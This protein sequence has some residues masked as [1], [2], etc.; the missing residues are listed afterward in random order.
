MAESIGGTYRR[1][2]IHIWMGDHGHPETMSVRDAG[3]RGWAL[4]AA[5]TIAALALL[6]GAW[7]GLFFQ[8]PWNLLFAGLALG[9]PILTLFTVWYLYEVTWSR[10]LRKRQAQE[11]REIA[12]MGTAE[13]LLRLTDYADQLL[14]RLT[15]YTG[16]FFFLALLA[17]FVVPVAFNFVLLGISESGGLLL[18]LIAAAL[19]LAFWAAYFY[20]YYT[21]KHQNDLWKERIARLR[22]RERSLAER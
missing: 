18:S 15:K 12:T 1:G 10:E 19:N 4:V 17:I 14:D 16:W 7:S 21:I 22:E 8:P 6:L 11:T 3:K 9:V 13:A 20:Y 5:T 2:V